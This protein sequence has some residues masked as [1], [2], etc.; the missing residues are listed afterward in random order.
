MRFRRGVITRVA[1]V[2][3][4]LKVGPAATRAA[5]PYVNATSTMVEFVSRNVVLIKT[6][7]AATSRADVSLTGFG[8][9]KRFDMRPSLPLYPTNLVR[10][11]RSFRDLHA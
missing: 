10:F 8:N 3:S 11:Y 9:G 5:N 2:A 1:I 7:P 4:G 6:T